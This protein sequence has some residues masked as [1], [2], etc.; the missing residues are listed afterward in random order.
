MPALGD[1][2]M[3]FLDAFGVE[4]VCILGCLDER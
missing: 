1:V 4:E 2:G 3:N